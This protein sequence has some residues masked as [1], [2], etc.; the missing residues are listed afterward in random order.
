MAEG[1]VVVIDPAYQDHLR[2]AAVYASAVD[3]HDELTALAADPDRLGE[4]RERGYA[5]C[6]EVLSAEAAVGLVK[7]LAGPGEDNR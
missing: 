7:E 2:G 4:Y 6:R 5:F 3:I 1:A